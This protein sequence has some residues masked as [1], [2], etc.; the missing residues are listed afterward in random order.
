VRRT[1]LATGFQHDFPVVEDGRVVGMLARDDVLR[2][3][4]LHGPRTPAHDVMH[5]RLPIA[6]AY[7]QLDAMRGMRP[8]GLA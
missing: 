1:W 2:G 4:V 7:E 6:G 3:L 5:E 8:G